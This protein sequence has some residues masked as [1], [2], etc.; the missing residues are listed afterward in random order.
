MRRNKSQIT[1]RSPDQSLIVTL[2]QTLSLQKGSMADR[3]HYQT[4]MVNGRSPTIPKNKAEGRSPVKNDE[5]ETNQQKK[6]RLCAIY[7]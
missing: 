4:T 2:A 3:Q 1:G 7:I 6:E 5:R